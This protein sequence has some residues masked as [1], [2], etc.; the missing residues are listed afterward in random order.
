MHQQFNCKLDAVSKIITALMGPI[1]ILW[2]WVILVALKNEPDRSYQYL[3]MAIGI[4]LLIVYVGCY[5]YMPLHYSINKS[6]LSIARKINTTHYNI[7][8]IN[9][10]Q[11]TSKKE[12][13]FVLRVMGNGGIFGYTGYF[14]CKS[15]GRMLWYVTNTQELILIKF[16]NGKSICLSP[17]DAAGFV[18]AINKAKK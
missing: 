5:L 6:T 13:G 15:I 2:P 12:M 3:L 8:D 4:L 9:T 1:F 10:I 16:I 11:A 17:S 7:A 18:E 14:N